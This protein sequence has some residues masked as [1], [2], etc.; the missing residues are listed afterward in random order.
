MWNIVRTPDHLH[1]Y[2][3]RHGKWDP[4]LS[5]AESFESEAWLAGL[6]FGDSELA[7]DCNI[8]GES[9]CFT[10]FVHYQWPIIVNSPPAG[11]FQ[12]CHH[13]LQAT[14][15]YSHILLLN[16]KFCGGVDGRTKQK[17][18]KTIWMGFLTTIATKAQK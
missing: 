4:V 1:I 2:A 8:V 5:C 13:M 6:M 7:W 11:R 12:Y 10:G 18:N 15:R 9:L 16:G 14:V 17:V 3:Y